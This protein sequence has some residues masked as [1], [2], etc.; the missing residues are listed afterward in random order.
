VNEERAVTKRRF[1]MGEREMMVGYLLLL[2]GL[3]GLAIFVVYPVI[4]GVSLAFQS[5][6]L[7]EPD[8]NAWVGLANFAKFLFHEPKLGLYIGN[9]VRWVVGSVIGRIT[10]GMILAL[11]LNRDMPFRGIYRALAL[12]PWVMPGVVA[13]IVWQ[14]IYNAN[15]GILNHVLTM[16]GMI[17]KN[18]VWLS[19]RKLIWPAIL[20][21]SIW[22]GYPFSYAFILAGLQ[23]IPHDLYEAAIIDGASRWSSFRHITLPML[24]PVLFVLLL[25]QTVWNANEFTAIWMLTKGGPADYTMTLAPLVYQTSFVFYRVGYGA[26]IAVLLS[27]V[28]LVFAIIYIRS[29]RSEI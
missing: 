23:V 7:L 1:G 6:Y 5:Q 12:V 15:W 25:L 4:S 17:Q 22:G 3:V 8:K 14:W 26:S 18:I 27:L 9:T 28:V 13:A 24:R 2:P 19:D 11:L 21:V 20:G 29:V 16:L 10:L